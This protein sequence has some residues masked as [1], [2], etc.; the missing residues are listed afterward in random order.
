MA[1]V[2]MWDIIEVLELVVSRFVFEGASGSSRTDDNYGRFALFIPISFI[3]LDLKR[4]IQRIIINF[5]SN[6]IVYPKNGC[7][8]KIS[9]LLL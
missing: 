8:L 4:F 7:L 1:D 3:W 2:E 5:F 6:S 9:W